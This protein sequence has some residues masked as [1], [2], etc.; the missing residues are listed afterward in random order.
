MTLKNTKSK[1]C[2]YG[3]S[4]VS[5]PGFLLFFEV[6]RSDTA[7]WTS[8]AKNRKAATVF[9]RSDTIRYGF[10]D[11]P[12]AELQNRHKNIRNCVIPWFPKAKCP[13]HTIS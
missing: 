2:R 7:S 9:S 6:T 3:A 1:P 10:L 11:K 4:Q 13:F 5:A 12:G 8:P